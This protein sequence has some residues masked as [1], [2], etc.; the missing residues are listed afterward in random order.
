MVEDFERKVFPKKGDVARLKEKFLV[1]EATISM[2]LNFRLNSPK[3][4]E[5]RS[6]AVNYLKCYFIL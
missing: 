2:A 6:Y 1:S 5:I 3:A 4:R